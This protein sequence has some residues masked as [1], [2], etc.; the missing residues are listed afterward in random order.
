MTAGAVTLPGREVNAARASALGAGALGTIVVAAGSLVLLAR[1]FVGGSAHGRIALFAISYVAIGCASL[2]IAGA[3][4]PVGIRRSAGERGTTG[5]RRAL[6]AG[7][8]LL[9]GLAAVAMAAVVAGTP[10]P[11][12]LVAAALPLS[13]LAAV[14]EEALF[15]R[16]AFAQLERLGPAI[17]VLGSAALFALVHLPAYGTTALPVDLGAGVLFGWQR[18]VSGSWTVPAMTHAAANLLA[19]LR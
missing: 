16:V 15:R 19:V 13:L 7:A 9:V 17:A 6:S 5:S 8:T 2:A 3:R 14:A 4:R 18:W 1:P 12:P 11:S 10:V